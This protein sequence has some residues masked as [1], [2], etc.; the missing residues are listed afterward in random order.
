M[1]EYLLSYGICIETSL[2]KP[3]LRLTS[4]MKVFDFSEQATLRCKAVGG[5]PPVR[6]ITLMKNNQVILN[7]ASDKITYTTS[8]GLPRNLYG[9]YDCI[10]SNTAGTV[11]ETILLQNKGDQQKLH[12]IWWLIQI[13]EYAVSLLVITW[14]LYFLFFVSP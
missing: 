9:L 6:N 11:S 12:C 14:W 8:G 13:K 5:Y 7:R 2:E 1:Y 3:E 4:S 10:A